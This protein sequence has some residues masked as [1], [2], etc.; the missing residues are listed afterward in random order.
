[1]NKFL[2]Y[3]QPCIN[4]SDKRLVE[5]ALFSGIL[6]AGKNV[7]NF[8]NKFSDLC[9]SKYSVACSSGTTALHLL[10]LALE[11][12]KETSVIVPSITFMASANAFKILGANIILCDVDQNS[13]L[14]SV[15]KISKIIREVPKNHKIIVVVVHL[16]GRIVDTKSIKE[17]LTK[18]K[19]VII[20]DACH[21]TGSYIKDKSGIDYVGSC[22]HSLASTFSFHPTKTFT[23]GEGG[24]ITTNHKQ[25]KDKLKIL[26]NH[27]FVKKNGYYHQI[28]MSLNFRLSELNAALGCSQ[29]SRI[30]K[31][32]SQRN[33]LR[34]R[35]YK[36]LVANNLIKT[37][38]DRGKNLLDH[39]FQVKINFKKLKKAREKIMLY[40]FSKNI[41]TQIHYKPLYSHKVYKNLFT[42]NKFNGTKIFFDKTLTLPFHN[43]LTTK[44]I[45][46]ISQ[47]LTEYILK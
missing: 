47:N 10:A 8:E 33:I 9:K 17:I 4:S 14:I 40:L 7:E 42:E 43:N 45:D 22:R 20:E 36:N 44:D 46:Y 23:T 25:L 38:E 21:A 12:N 41:G 6:T 3:A 16:G 15:E 19:G 27:G 24:A 5:K 1:M 31:V 34:K 2:H 39:L 37:Y 18:R 32:R 28:K 30:E 35:Y 13:G 11:V 29:I 26:R